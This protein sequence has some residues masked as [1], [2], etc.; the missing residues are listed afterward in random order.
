MKTG[1][2]LR[3]DFLAATGGSFVFDALDELEDIYFFVKDAER[4]FVYYNRSFGTLMWHEHDELLG[5][6]DEEI[7]P[8][9]LVEKYRR[10]DEEV[11]N[12]GTRI[13]NMTE[14]V[15][16]LD[17]SYDWFITNKFPV[18]DTAGEIVG[19][20]GVTRNITKRMSSTKQF[21]AL[22]PAVELMLKEFSR[23]LR[24]ED[25]AQTVALSPSQFNRQFKKRFGVT[26]HN[27]LRQVRMMAASNLLTTTELPISDIATQCGF[28]DQSH[29]THDFS[30]K[31]GMS[32]RQYRE[33]FSGSAQQPGLKLVV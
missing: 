8:E 5:L 21:V 18:Y 10:D 11:I 27:Y 32:P 16:N 14:L 30:A 26:P 15:H 6:R 31:R 22:A 29:L 9:Y 1:A 12:N 33:R 17:G 4:R 20:A 13:V 28:S 24:V 3:A 19:V 25:L 7:S 23:P 2:Q